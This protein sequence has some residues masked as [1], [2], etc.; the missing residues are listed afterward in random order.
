MRRLLVLRATER[1]CHNVDDWFDA[2]NAFLNGSFLGVNY[3][4]MKMQDY[5]LGVE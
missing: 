3:L 2:Q 5:S 1:I 4:Y